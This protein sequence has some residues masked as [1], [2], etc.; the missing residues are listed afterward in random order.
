VVK[1]RTHAVC[2]VHTLALDEDLVLELIGRGKLAFHRRNRDN[3]Q[4]SFW[5]R[6]LANKQ[7]FSLLHLV[8][9]DLLHDLGHDALLLKVAVNLER[10]DD[11]VRRGL[12]GVLVD[13]LDGVAELDPARERVAVVDDWV[14][15]TS[16]PVFLFHVILFLFCDRT[17]PAVELDAAAA[18]AESVDVGL[19]GGRSSQLVLHEVGVVRRVDVVVVEREVHVLRQNLVFFFFVVP[20]FERTW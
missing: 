7:I 4:L 8:A 13:R 5:N 20:S 12:E 14:A 10:E 1:K 16:V 17:V 15:I 9:K 19:D 6:W 3:V 2:K 18:L 11:G